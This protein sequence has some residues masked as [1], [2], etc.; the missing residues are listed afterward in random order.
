M[1]SV[2]TSCFENQSLAFFIYGFRM[3][4]DLNVVYFLKRHY[5]VDLC[6]GECG[7]RFDIRTE[8]LNT[9]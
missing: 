7:V 5:P 8:F 2:F 9:I 6:N 1:V 3:I 4:I